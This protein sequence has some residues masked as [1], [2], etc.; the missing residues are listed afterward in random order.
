MQL[1]P[2]PFFGSVQLLRAIQLITAKA[3]LKFYFEIHT[4]KRYAEFL[5]PV[6]QDLKSYGYFHY[7][8]LGL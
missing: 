6:V 2:N 3:I 1:P 4:R 8:L 7:L 5:T